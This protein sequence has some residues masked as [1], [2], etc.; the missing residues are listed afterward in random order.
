MVALTY[1]NPVTM[2]SITSG[3]GLP[4]VFN[5]DDANLL[6]GNTINRT[7]KEVTGCCDDMDFTHLFDEN[8]EK[9]DDDDEPDYSPL[10]EIQADYVA[11]WY[12][13][14][15]DGRLHFPIG[16]HFVKLSDEL[17]VHRQKL[18]LLE[19]MNF[20]HACGF[21]TWA[22]LSDSG[23]TNVAL[24]K[25]FTASQDS[26]NSDVK[27]AIAKRV[28]EAPN[29]TIGDCGRSSTPTTPATTATVVQTRSAD[30]VPPPTPLDP[31]IAQFSIPHPIEPS[32]M[33]LF[34]LPDIEHL[35]KAMRN[36]LYAS[37][38]EIKKK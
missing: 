18:W 14:S 13:S 11:Q 6:R 26:A 31:D 1:L 9:T 2:A 20:L 25:V 17:R 37:R 35:L 16:H 36:V 15:L 7:T 24:R 29:C 3:K 12:W 5:T 32:P 10:Q 4:G 8:E 21:R 33:R 34:F 23:S 19:G 30:A 38:P 22:I 27:A 28:G